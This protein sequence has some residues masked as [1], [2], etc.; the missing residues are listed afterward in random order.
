MTVNIEQ[1]NGMRYGSF[2]ILGIQG[3]VPQQAITSTNLNHAKDSGNPNFNFKTNILKIIEF[4]PMKLTNDEDYKK[5]RIKNLLTC[6]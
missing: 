2:N 4:D 3:N 5:T 6:D 1:Q